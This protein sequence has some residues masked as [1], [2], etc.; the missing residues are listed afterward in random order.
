MARGDYF[1]VTF[2]NVK[3]P[4][5]TEVD[6]VDGRVTKEYP[7]AIT[8][9]AITGSMYEAMLVAE[10]T[11][12]SVVAVNAKG[13]DYV[14]DGSVTDITVTYTAKDTIYNAKEDTNMIRI[15]LPDQW[16]PAYSPHA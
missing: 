7:L 13:K 14:E 6:L 15:D 16:E 10:P 11:K 3:V 4:Y 2:Y 8:D 5:L 1:E 12:L 9:S